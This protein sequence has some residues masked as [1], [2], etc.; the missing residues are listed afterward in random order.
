METASIQ[1][2]A[3]QGLDLAH[4][5]KMWPALSI[6]IFLATKY[7]LGPGAEKFAWLKAIKEKPLYAFASPVVL[8]LAGGLATAATSG[9]AFT[10]ELVLTVLFDALKLSGGAMFAFLAHANGKEHVAL[11]KEAGAQAA[12]KVKTTDQAIAELGKVD[13]LKEITKP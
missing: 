5:G 8:A 4:D 13:P 9:A 3:K 2:L 1:D 7:L 6:G 10:P 12:A 11:A